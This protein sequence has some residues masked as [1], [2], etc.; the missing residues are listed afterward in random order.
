FACRATRTREDACAS[1][2]IRRLATQAFREPVGAPEFDIL[3]QLYAG[4]RQKN[5]FESGIRLALQGILASPRFLFRLEEPAAA[6]AKTGA[7]SRISDL[8]LA[9]R[10]SFFLWGTVPDAALLKAASQGAL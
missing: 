5:G 7:P 8:A 9:S 10:L 2:I 3:M 1:E 6:V 4:E